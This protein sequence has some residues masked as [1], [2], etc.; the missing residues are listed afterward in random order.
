MYFIDIV[1]SSY[2][3]GDVGDRVRTGRNHDLYYVSTYLGK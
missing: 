3:T 2:A 1:D